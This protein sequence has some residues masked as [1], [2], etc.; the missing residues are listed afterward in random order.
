MSSAFIVV[1][2]NFVIWFPFIVLM[3]KKDRGGAAFMLF[4]LILASIIAYW[5]IVL[6]L[7]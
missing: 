7:V 1:V 6:G 4:T 5:N 2:V 3:W